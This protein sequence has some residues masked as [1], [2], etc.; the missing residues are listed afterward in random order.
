MVPVKLD[1]EKEGKPVAQKYK[2]HVKGFPT[3][4]FLNNQG[5]VEGKIGGYMP[6]EGFAPEMKKFI[7][8]HTE[9][10]KAEAKY[11]AGDR[12]LS[13]LAKLVWGYA[14]RNQGAKAEALLPDAE[15]AANGK[16]TLELA[17]AYNAVG[18]YHQLEERYEKAVPYF[19][20][21]AKSSDAT[22][23]TYALIS[24]ASC[25]MSEQKLEEAAKE[26]RALIAMPDATPTYK[27]QAEQMLKGIEGALKRN[28]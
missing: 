22:E 12:S 28:P 9:F 20:K 7:D 13:T 27:K 21:A 10:P 24:I 15:K 18:D 4:L 2:E 17:K 23:V 8:L 11:K 6:P 19:R 25:Y 5:E 1:A 16:V 14:G 3:I 26:L